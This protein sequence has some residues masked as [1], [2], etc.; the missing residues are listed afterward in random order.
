MDVNPGDGMDGITVTRSV[1]ASAPEVRVATGRGPR[2]AMFAQAT[3]GSDGCPDGDSVGS[4]AAKPSLSISHNVY[5]G[6]LRAI[7]HLVFSASPKGE[8]ALH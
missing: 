2:A 5:L 3:A 7:V 8:S 6:S 4:R 1:R